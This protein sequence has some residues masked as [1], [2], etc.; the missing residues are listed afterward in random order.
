MNVYFT[1]YFRVDPKIL[2]DYGAF[3]ISLINDLPLFIDPF[4][5]FESKK[6]EY[7]QL[8]K[9]ILSYV[10]F[11]RDISLQM[12][13]DDGLLK[14]LFMFSE[15]KQNWLGYCLFGNDGNGL[16]KTFAVALRKNLNTVFSNFGKESVTKESHIEK[17]CIVKTGVGR[18]NIS[19]F[20]VNLIKKYLCEYT[21]EFAL[22]HIDSKYIKSF[23]VEK[24]IFDKTTKRWKPATYQLPYLDNDYV[25]LTPKDILTKD[26]NWINS[27]D[28]VRNFI[29]IADSIPNDQLRSNINLYFKENLPKLTKKKTTI[30]NKEFAAAVSQVINKY[31]EFLDY[32]IK[33]KEDNGEKAKSI[34]KEKVEYVENYYINNIS[35]FIKALNTLTDFYKKRID[36]Y[37]EAL[38]RVMYL[39]QVIENNDGY[40]IFYIKGKPI[41]REDDLHIMFRLTWYATTS[42]VNSEVNNGRGPVDFKISKGKYDKVLV[43][44]KLASNSKLEQNLQH[45]VDVY[46]KASQT[47]KDIKVILYFSAEEKRKVDKILKKLKLENMENVVLID[48]RKDNKISASNVK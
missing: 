15:V 37:K 27:K 35:F 9:D 22:K 17:L 23:A 29:D 10:A 33:Y 40:K 47:D 3:N 4:L 24:A 5:L 19:D 6:P 18:D 30:T 34:S 13:I 26:D 16:G 21:Q 46:K 44:F 38:E 39:K 20:T 8:H 2:E 48:A 25:L 41:K 14:S 31:P 32:Y 12:Q 36:T 7:K 42:D 43:E 28:I 1:D 45:Q 11:L